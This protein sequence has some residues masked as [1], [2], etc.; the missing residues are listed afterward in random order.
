MSTACRY[1]ICTNGISVQDVGIQSEVY[2]SCHSSSNGYYGYLPVKPYAEDYAMDTSDVGA[3]NSIGNGT[4][5]KNGPCINSLTNIQNGN[6][7]SVGISIGR[8][9][10]INEEVHFT[11]KPKRQ[12]QEEQESLNEKNSESSLQFIIEGCD[13]DLVENLLKETHGCDLYHYDACDL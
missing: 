10:R 5:P 2:R 7:L 4:D 8:R 6:V 9:K 11:G 1:E 13:L 12:R 3:E